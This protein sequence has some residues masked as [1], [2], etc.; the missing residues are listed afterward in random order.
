MIIIYDNCRRHVKQKKE[1]KKESTSREETGDAK[2]KWWRGWH[3]SRVL[4]PDPLSDPQH[5]M[6]SSSSSLSPP[7]SSQ[8][9]K[10]KGNAFELEFHWKYDDGV[11]R[12]DWNLLKRKP[13]REDM[14]S[15]CHGMLCSM[16]FLFVAM[17]WFDFVVVLFFFL[18]CISS[19][20]E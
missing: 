2:A 16:F 4:G 6:T 17:T 20:F 5:V 3:D 18:F 10:Y 13:N 7:S 8:F 9:N 15:A 11:L 12:F 1:R 19:L 14:W